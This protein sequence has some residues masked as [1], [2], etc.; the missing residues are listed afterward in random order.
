MT[1]ACP[2]CGCSG[3]VQKVSA[4]VNTGTSQS[5]SSGL[6]LGGLITGDAHVRPLAAITTTHA[7]I[8]SR[9]AKLLAPPVSPPKPTRARTSWVA[10]TVVALVSA[11]TLW[12]FPA[13]VCAAIFLVGAGLLWLCDHSAK[14]AFALQMA[15]YSAGLPTWEETVRRWERLYYCSRDDLVFDPNTNATCSPQHL[16]QFLKS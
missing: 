2:V 9:I 6:S 7:Q 8:T 1:V 5:T 12:C 10:I 4:V 11:C 3:A 16:Q 13:P 15:D 14:Q